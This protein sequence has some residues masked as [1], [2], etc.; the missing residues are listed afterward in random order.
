MYY[1][2]FIIT[3]LIKLTFL[4]K[5]EIYSKL[6]FKC[7]LNRDFEMILFRRYNNKSNVF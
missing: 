4:I 7:V 5:I 6:T 3:L 1:L 2:I